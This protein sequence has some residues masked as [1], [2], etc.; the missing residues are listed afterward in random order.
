MVRGLSM[1]DAF[2]VGMMN[3]GITPSIWTMTTWGLGTYLT[4]NMVWATLISLALV[5]FGYPLVW[6]ILSGSMPRSGGEYIYNSRI[7]HPIVG[8]RGELRQRLRDDLLGLRAGAVGRR[9]RVW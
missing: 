2:A 7:I 1:I 4:G 6:G 8:H 9:P 5:G 3:Q